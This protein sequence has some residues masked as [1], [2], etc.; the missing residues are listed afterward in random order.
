[1]AY[2][3]EGT[4]KV[5]MDT[6]RFD[7]GFTKRELILTTGEERY[8]QDIKLEFVKDR[9]N[10]LDRFQTGQRVKV[11]FDI[12]GGEHNGRY[13]VNLSAFRIYP[14]DGSP[15]PPAPEGGDRERRG[16]FRDFQDKGG[17]G[18][19]GGKN[20]DRERYQGG[21]RDRRGGYDGGRERRGG[22]GR[23]YE[24]S[25]GGRR[26]GRDYDDDIDF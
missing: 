26:G 23:N 6:L 20:F 12:R 5:I 18:P 14:A 16:G 21:D 10:L 15:P 24:D 1:M 7:S 9:V 4:I 8:P 17:G 11:D 3:I 19:R 25:F 2:E 22:G 13:Y